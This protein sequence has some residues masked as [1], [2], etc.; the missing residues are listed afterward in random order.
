MPK[1]TLRVSFLVTLVAED[2]PSLSDPLYSLVSCRKE[3]TRVL[4]WVM[5]ISG[6]EG[7]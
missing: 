4:A 7:R 5:G 3:G 1:L 6:L 2:M